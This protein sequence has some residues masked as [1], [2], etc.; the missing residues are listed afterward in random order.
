MKRHWLADIHFGHANIVKYCKRPT[1]RKGD[2]TPAGEWVS[3]AIALAAAERQD[4]FLIRNLNQRIKPDDLVIH[5]GDFMNRGVCKGTAGLRNNPQ[6]YLDQLNG[7]WTLLEGNHDKNN[8]VKPIGT[9]LIAKVSHFQVFVTHYPTDAQIMDQNGKW[10]PVHDP[11]LIRWARKSC[12]FAV[13]GH[14]HEKWGQKWLD[15]F[16]NIN[17]GIDVRKYTTTTDDELI[18]IYMQAKKCQESKTDVM[19]CPA[20]IPSDG[21][22]RKQ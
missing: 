12:Q 18:R 11:D 2:L 1:L 14:V 21:Q 8:K 9:Y 7:N 22:D 19:S 20:R 13:V 15:G 5:N 6:D 17:V 3:E 4:E 16:L 10:W